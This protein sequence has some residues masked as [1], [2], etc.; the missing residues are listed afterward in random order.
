MAHYERHQLSAVFGDFPAEDRERC[1]EDL[2]AKLVPP[3]EDGD[4]PMVPSDV[5]AVFL[6]EGQ[7]LD[8]WN[9][10]QWALALGAEIRFL[11]L[12]EGE[13]PVAWVIGKNLNRRH[14]PAARRAEIT[15]ELY[16]AAGRQVRG[17]GNPQLGNVAQLDTPASV[18]VDDVAQ[19]AGVSRST[20]RAVIVERKA[21]QVPVT[22]SKP[23]KTPLKIDRLQAEIDQVHLEK[24]GLARRLED[25]EAQVSQFIAAASDDVM[26]RNAEL[27]RAQAVNSGLHGELAHSKNTYMDTLIEMKFWRK[28]AKALGYVPPEGPEK[29]SLPAEAYQNEYTA[30]TPQAATASAPQPAL[31]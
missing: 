23:P 18:S 15:I 22:E 17:A 13:D 20:V 3:T 21:E 9:R 1:I 2:R 28:T 11:D 27:R 14:L 29:W 10:Y 19:Q 5:G 30:S 8:G 31:T 25:V 24:A 4:R 12:P 16:E 7:I 26:E 6:Y